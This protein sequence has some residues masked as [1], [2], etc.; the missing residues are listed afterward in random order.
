MSF[1]LSD[2]RV[3]D[4]QTRE[5][6]VAQGNIITMLTRRGYTVPHEDWH[7][8]YATFVEVWSLKASHVA[9][10]LVGVRDDDV[11]IVFFPFEEKLRIQSIREII[12]LFKEKRYHHLIIVYSGSVTSFAKQQLSIIRSK[13]SDNP[14]RIETF[15]IRSFQYDLFAHQY[16]PE[17]AV[18]NVAEANAL[19][20]RYKIGVMDLPKIYTTDPVAQYFGMRPKQ[21]LR[22]VCPSPEGYFYTLYRVCVKG[23]ILK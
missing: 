3:I 1:C 14:V 21:V 10:T 20:E 18:L 19:C 9:F 8:D 7:D 6:F 11:V 22:V 13:K 16:V 17:Q 4:E 12:A 15:N 23:N 2:L 5:M